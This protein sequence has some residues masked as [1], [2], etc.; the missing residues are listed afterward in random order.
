[1]P[2]SKLFALV[3]KSI[4][5]AITRTK[6][7]PHTI[8]KSRRDF[9][10]LSVKAA[11]LASS[12]STV[13]VHA[14]SGKASPRIA[15]IGAGLAGLTAAYELEK[16]GLT[17]TIYEGS[18]RIGGR[19]QT[20]YNQFNTETYSENGGEFVDSDHKT[21]QRLCA[22]N[23]IPLID[24]HEDSASSNLVEQN[25]LVDGT[26]YTERD[27]LEEFSEPSRIIASDLKSCGSSFETEV[28]TKLDNTSL[29]EY[30]DLLPMQEWLKKLLKAAYE[31]QFGLPCH[32]QSSLNLISM[33]STTLEEFKVFGQSDERFRIAGGSQRLI[34]TIKKEIS[35]PIE[36]NKKLVSVSSRDGYI[37]AGFQDG[38]YIRP[39]HLILAIPF[40]TL[41]RVELDLDNLPQEKLLGIQELGYGRNCKL[42]LSANSRGWR[43]DGSVGAL[44]NEHIQ[45]G[46]D[47]TQGQTNN[48]GPGSYT[49]YLGA[50]ASDIIDNSERVRLEQLRDEYIR[51]INQLYPSTLQ[52]FTGKLRVVTWADKPE[53]LGSYPCYKV[54]QWTTLAGTEASQVGRIYFA[55]DHTS[56]R[57]QGY[58][59]GAAESG[60]RVANE[61]NQMILRSGSND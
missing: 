59:N 18:S 15:I 34:S 14:N 29:D 12:A 43:K 20:V 17:S 24:L 36:I 55:G 39:D 49:I 56:E 23:K 48:T 51:I 7:T 33:I 41:R 44:I 2:R 10:S 8:N 9:L 25:Y 37:V 45:N 19:I 42:I 27:I 31:A 47:S 13:R 50:P 11:I 28:S 54:G 61:V 6:E 22:E 21:I 38:S 3:N 52:E 5:M 40:S 57:F 16:R 4:A 30:I 58:M 35:S 46:W 32:E 53:A 60:V 1:M 26:G